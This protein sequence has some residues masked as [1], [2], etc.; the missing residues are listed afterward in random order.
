MN[1]GKDKFGFRLG[2][3]RSQGAQLAERGATQAEIRAAIG[4]PLY[5]MLRA[6]QKRGHHVVRCGDRFWLIHGSEAVDISAEIS[7]QLLGERVK[8]MPTTLD[9]AR[10]A[11][12][13]AQYRNASPEQKERVSRTIERGPIGALV[14]RANRFQCQL[15]AALCRDPIG[16]KKKNGE[17]YVEAHHVVPAS[18]QQI[19]SL[20]ALNVMTL[21]ANHHR[22]VHFGCA[23]IVVNDDMFEVLISGERVQIPRFKLPPQ[24][25]AE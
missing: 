19:G 7:Q 18:T 4:Y 3:K 1:A 13:E 6:A 12:L 2:K 20:A 21:C 22:E 16:F 10:L 14:K 11:R 24:S 15:C 5:N 9:M 23:E 8:A 25:G 17:P